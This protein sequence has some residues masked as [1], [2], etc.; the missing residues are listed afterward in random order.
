MSAETN[1]AELETDFTPHAPAG[2]PTLSELLKR[3]DRIVEIIHQVEALKEEVCAEASALHRGHLFDWYNERHVENKIQFTDVAYWNHVLYAYGL[4]S[5][6]TEKAKAAWMERIEKEAPPFS[7]EN[8]QA[9]VQNMEEKYR[10]DGWETVKEVY[11]QLIGCRYQ[12]PRFMTKL[13]NLQRV[14]EVFRCRGNIS[15]YTL[16]GR[17]DYKSEWRNGINYDDVLTACFLLD[18]R[19]KPT[20][21]NDLYRISYETFLNGGDTLETE[22]FT[23]RCYKNGNQK[24]HWKKDKLDSLARLNKVGSDGGLPDPLKKRYKPAH[25]SNGQFDP[26]AARAE[27]KPGP[28]PEFYP[29]PEPI[30]HAL[31]DLADC[32]GPGPFLEPSAGTG[33][34]AKLLGKRW[35]KESVTCVELGASRAAE[36]ETAG[37]PTVNMDF[38]A[39]APT[40]VYRRIIMNPPFHNQA[41]VHHVLHA[42]KF[43][44]PKARL[45][46]VMA[47]SIENRDSQLSAYFRDLVRARG[48]WFEKLPKDAFLEAGT[49]VRT[50]AVVIPGAEGD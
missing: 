21:A 29:T 7:L 45:V 34:I 37:F 28:D 50:V 1:T 23:V 26:D 8:C 9:L 35:S 47:A 32:D 2:I 13:D 39:M 36:L 11:R 41:D 30:V 6:M 38:L 31:L 16:G 40:P 44:L 49:R 4:T 5:S 19:G 42:L 24:V 27:F 17:F 43:M 33:A 46:S 25:F 10:R 22:Y 14:E 48:G 12:G 18:G 3:R 20:Y 15:W